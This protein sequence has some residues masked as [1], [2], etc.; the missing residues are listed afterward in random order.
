PENTLAT[1]A[2]RHAADHP[3]AVVEHEPRA[4]LALATGDPLHDHALRFVN[5]DRHQRPSLALVRWSRPGISRSTKTAPS[6][7]PIPSRRHSTSQA[8]SS[9]SLAANSSAPTAGTA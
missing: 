2:R 1:L 3:G 5:E 4:S 9:L 7:P 8:I 6:G